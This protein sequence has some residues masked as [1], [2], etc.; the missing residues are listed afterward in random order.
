MREPNKQGQYGNFTVY[1]AVY[2]GIRFVLE[3]A[4]GD[5]IRGIYGMFSTSQWISL[6]ILISLAALFLKT[7]ESCKMIG[8][9]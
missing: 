1:L 4:R 7:Q 6:S 3:F 2:A 8:G 5:E 9:E